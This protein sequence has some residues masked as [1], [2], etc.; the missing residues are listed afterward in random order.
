MEY[1]K[2]DFLKSS[3]WPPVLRA[4][5]NC[6][7]N[8]NFKIAYVICAITCFCT[9]SPRLTV[10]YIYDRI[11]HHLLLQVMIIG[12]SSDGKSFA[13]YIYKLILKPLLDRDKAAELEELKFAE[14]KRQSGNSKLKDTEPVT[15]K[16]CLLKLTK[17]KIV[18][19]AHM[20]IRK[21]GEALSFFVFTDELST[22]LERRGS[23]GDLRDISKLAY[24]W[25]SETSVDTNCDA[26]YNATVGIYWNSIFC[27][28]PKILYKYIDKDAV[29][30]GGANRLTNVL[31]GDL[32]GEEAP[33]FKG[34]TEKDMTLIKQWQD[35]LMDET[36]KDENHL[37]PMKE[38]PMSWL[39]KD[40]EIWCEHQREIISKTCSHAHNCFYKRASVSAFRI[41]AMTY[42]LWGEN[43]RKRKNVRRIYYYF[44][45]YI[46][47]GQMK[48]FGK[49]YE[50]AMVDIDGNSGDEADENVPLYD[51]IPKRF[52]RDQLKVKA[53]QLNYGTKARQFIFKWLKKHL[54]YE[55][56][57]MKDTYEK[58]Y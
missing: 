35:K 8:L 23:Y 26:S 42:H 27:T 47:D 3:D 24:D 19:R 29:E 15:V 36:Y 56:E 22:L 43:E 57:G 13:R 28:T 30:S 50:E 49:K 21:F 9:L 34:L 18:K 44:A 4:F 52:T 11:L 53:E 2:I 25:G 41:A 51:Q 37:Q 6:V 5:W 55:V 48:L 40:V 38:I 17:N 10:K 32:L 39:D 1:K 14:K 45:D 54:I 33:K 7:D 12:Q 20:M 46:L 58:L 16:L 31:L